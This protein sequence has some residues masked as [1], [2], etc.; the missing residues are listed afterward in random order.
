M[1]SP[2]GQAILALVP[3]GTAPRAEQRG[4]SQAGGSRWRAGGGHRAT[5]RPMVCD[6]GMGKV[7][8][9]ARRH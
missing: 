5:G 2:A 1:L 4:C 6:G 8:P 9:A 3:R 7:L